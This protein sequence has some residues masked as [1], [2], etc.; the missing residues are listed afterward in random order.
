LEENNTMKKTLLTAFICVT[1]ATSAVFAQEHA[2]L[3]INGPS[4][5]ARGTKVTVAVQDKYFNLEGSYGFSYWL[6]V[7][8]TVAPFLSITGLKYFP[9]FNAGYNGPFPIFFDQNGVDSADLGATSNPLHCVPDGSYHVTNITFGI[10]NNAPVGTYTLHITT[11]NPRPSIQ[12]DCQFNDVPIS[13]ISFVF[14]VV[15]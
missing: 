7:N 5:W 9:P 10:A 13:Q 2:A 1:T 4:S 8:T 6:M 3:S 12:S 14:N 15:P 11:G